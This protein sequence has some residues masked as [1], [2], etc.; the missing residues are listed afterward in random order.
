MYFLAAPVLDDQGQIMRGVGTLVD[1]ADKR[2]LEDELRRLS[3]TD[4]LTG[5]CNQRFVFAILGREVESA[6]RY[7]NSFCLL[8]LDLDNF[9]SFNDSYG[10]LEGDRVLAG[11][12]SE[13]RRQVGT[14][15]LVCCYG[16]EEFMVFTPPRSSLE[17][18]LTV[19]R[20]VR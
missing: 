3:V 19:A 14:S 4:E 6:W 5:L 15:D 1:F 11:C 12:A 20:R 18:A 13:L 8:L 17:E 10:H 9:K 2:C 7:G 16:G